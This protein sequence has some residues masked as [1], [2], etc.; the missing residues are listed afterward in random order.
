[1]LTLCPGSVPIYRQGCLHSVLL[2]SRRH[3]GRRRSFPSLMGC[4]WSHPSLEHRDSC[5]ECLFSRASQLLPCSPSAS[6]NVP[7]LGYFLLMGTSM[8]W[9]WTHSHFDSQSCNPGDCC[10]PRSSCGFTN[11]ITQ[12]WISNTATT[13]FLHV[14]TCNSPAPKLSLL[15]HACNQFVSGVSD[16]TGLD[17]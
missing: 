15:L 8:I 6:A 11:N 14:P 1:M 17:A 13:A 10:L 3:E 9:G 4:L 16:S 12:D 5:W 2:S 7:G